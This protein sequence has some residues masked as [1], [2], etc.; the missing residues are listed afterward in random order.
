MPDLQRMGFDVASFGNNSFVIH[1][2]PAALNAGEEKKTLDEL[3]EQLKH[4]SDKT[5]AGYAEN[6]VLSLAKRLSYYT[7]TLHQPEAQQ[8]LIDELFACTQPQYTPSGK[9]IFSILK[10]DELEDLLDH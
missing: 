8:T 10:K 5:G 9:K 2:T 6:M 3:L 1:A 4:E 7:H